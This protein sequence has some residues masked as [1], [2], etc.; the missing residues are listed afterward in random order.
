[1]K[2]T[3]VKVTPDI[4]ING[5]NDRITNVSFHPLAKPRTIPVMNDPK[6]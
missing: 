5:D 2:N 1:M 3:L 6:N 4:N